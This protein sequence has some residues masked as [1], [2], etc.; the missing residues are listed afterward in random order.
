MMK[1]PKDLFDSHIWTR[2]PIL[3]PRKTISDDEAED[4]RRGRKDALEAAIGPTVDFLPFSFL[5]MGTRRGR[6]VARVEVRH[7]EPEG[8]RT[9]GTGTGFL[10]APFLLM[11]N[12]HVLPSVASAKDSLAQFNYE[13]DILGGEVDPD[14]WQLDPDRL[15]VTSPFEE[16]DFTV[17][18]L[19]PKGTEEAGTTY[20]TIPLRADQAKTMRGERVLVIQHPAGRRKEVVLHESK[21]TEFLEGGFLHYTADTLVGSSGSPVFNDQWD[22]VA[23]HHRGVIRLDKD[24]KPIMEGSDFI[25]DANEGIRVSAIVNK[26]LS[27]AVPESA[28]AILKPFLYP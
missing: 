11:T 28:Q 24:G 26:L 1:M 4:I 17:V 16:L 23:L 19:K 5:P 12:H 8:V 13:L 7:R 21:V 27:P 2:Q 22:I 20:G 9:I 25:C 14:D 3:A 15:F 10:I 6:A 18:A